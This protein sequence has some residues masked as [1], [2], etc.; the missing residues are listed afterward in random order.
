MAHADDQT[1]VQPEALVRKTK[2]KDFNLSVE[3]Y[4]E[5]LANGIDLLLVKRLEAWGAPSHLVLELIALTEKVQDET[6]TD[7]DIVRVV[8]IVSPLVL[9]RS[10]TP[11]SSSGRKRAAD[12]QT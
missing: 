7:A 9:R 3:A 12:S 11:R 10:V 4:L 2:I 8:A 1:S 5:G 6:A